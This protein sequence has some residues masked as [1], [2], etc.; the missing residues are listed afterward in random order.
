MGFGWAVCGARRRSNAAQAAK[1][2]RK[3][4]NAAEIDNSTAFSLRGVFLGVRADA[5]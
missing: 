4:A 3:S 1:S 5:A 2:T